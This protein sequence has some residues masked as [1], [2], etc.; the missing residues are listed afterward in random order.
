[1]C[2]KEEGK[3]KEKGAGLDWIRGGAPR[4]G[5]DGVLWFLLD[6]RGGPKSI[7][8]STISDSSI[9]SGCRLSIFDLSFPP[10]RHRCRRTPL[11][12]VVVS[13][14]RKF[15]SRVANV[16]RACLPP[17]KKVIHPPYLGALATFFPSPTFGRRV[18]AC[19][20]ARYDLSTARGGERSSSQLSLVSAKKYGFYP[21]TIDRLFSPGISIF[22]P[23]G[24]HARAA[25]FSY[26]RGN[27]PSSLDHLPS[28]N[29]TLRF[30]SAAA[31]DSSLDRRLWS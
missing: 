17:S 6:A 19:E 28:E 31:P 24:R 27:P 7:P 16:R 1:V 15:S 10:A 21:A 23:Q 12:V 30:R 13:S 22:D 11:A 18:L 14:T 29:F 9:F 4:A 25:R 5:L 8:L 26:L 20:S 2:E 3:R